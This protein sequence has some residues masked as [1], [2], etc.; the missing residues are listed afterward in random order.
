MRDS[1][2]PVGELLNVDE[3]YRKGAAS[4]SL[5]RITPRRFNPEKEKWLPILHTRREGRYYTAVF[6]NTARAH[7][8]GRT[9]DWVVLFY[10]EDDTSEGQ[11]TVVTEYHGALAG[12]R[13]VRGREAETIEHYQNA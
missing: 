4:G 9:R 11:A 10:H 5:P 12:R 8:L 1:R 6:S 3:E 13:V 7:A 2:P